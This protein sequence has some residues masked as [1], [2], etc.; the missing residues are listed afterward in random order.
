MFWQVKRL[1]KSLALVG[2]GGSGY[3]GKGG[4][5]HGIG[6]GGNG[7]ASS[8]G[9]S[10]NVKVPILRRCCRC[11]AANHYGD[12]FTA[13]LYE[14]CGGRGHESRKCASPPEAV[15]A[16]VGNPGGDAVEKTSF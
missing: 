4:E 2:K 11:K 15:L 16:M 13:K 12:S 5:A 8:N 3:G 1:V 7:N 10:G 14:R 9:E 6:K